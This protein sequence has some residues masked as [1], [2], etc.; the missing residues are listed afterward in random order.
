M[1]KPH[2][3]FRKATPVWNYN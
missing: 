2:F 3:Y 1:E